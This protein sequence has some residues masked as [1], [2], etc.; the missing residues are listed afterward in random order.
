[1]NLSNRYDE[2]RELSNSGGQENLSQGLVREL[3]FSFP[4]DIAEQRALANRLSS[5]SKLITAQKGK[6]S[7]LKSH[8]KGLM[9]QL[10]PSREEFL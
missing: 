9:Q 7:Q 1:L 10:F 5:I 4:Y 8:K 3:P 2:M 6:I